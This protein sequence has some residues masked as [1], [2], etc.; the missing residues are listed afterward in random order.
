MFDQSILKYR[1]YLFSIQ[2]SFRNWNVLQVNFRTLR[3]FDDEIN[4]GNIKAVSLINNTFTNF[5]FDTSF[6][7]KKGIIKISVSG[8]VSVFVSQ[9]SS[10]KI[11]K[12]NCKIV[13][14]KGVMY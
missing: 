2:Y 8:Y 3:S 12:E 10:S 13:I 1:L 9:N 5:L 14:H 7:P 4:Y 6:K 11:Y